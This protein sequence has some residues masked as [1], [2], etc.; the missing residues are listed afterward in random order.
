MTPLVSI[1]I[2]LYNNEKFICKTLNSVVEDSYLNKEIIVINDGSTDNSDEVVKEWIA[3][4]KGVNINYLSRKNK[5]L[6]YTL[7]ELFSL[8]L[9]KY[10]INIASDDFL[11]NNTIERRVELLEKNPEKL[12]LIGDCLIVDDSNNLS[13][14]SASFELHSGN[15]SKY[16]N[17]ES[18]KDEIL[19][20][21]ATVDPSYMLNRK[22]YDEIGFYD[23]ESY[24]E[25]WDFAVR[26]V[27]KNLILF[28]DEQVAAY[29]LHDTNTIKNKDAAIK[30]SQ[31]CVKTIEKHG[32]KF[33]LKDKI[34]LWNKARRLRR[35]IKR[36]QKEKINNEK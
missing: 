15:K 30:F 11:I 1:L 33:K 6:H 29:R 34:R 23:A 2:P 10:I 28:F 5:G 18:L 26:A 25:D 22:I 17:D 3:E 4:N 19:Y 9:G 13:D 31:S 35:K 21:W 24:L 7:N 36:L 8:S 16:F 27:S 12:M 14:I 20:N 32:S